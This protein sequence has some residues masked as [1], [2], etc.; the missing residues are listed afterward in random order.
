MKPSQDEVNAFLDDLRD[1]GE[2]NM[3]GAGPYVA[4]AF[5][6][7]KRTAREMLSV[8]MRTYAERHGTPETRK[9]GA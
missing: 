1:G 9:V 8:W 7:D 6:L 2:I 3:Y 5:D 4:D